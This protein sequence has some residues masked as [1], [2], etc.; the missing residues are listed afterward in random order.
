MPVREQHDRSFTMEL[1]YVGDSGYSCVFQKHGSRK[2]YITGT[3]NRNYRGSVRKGFA[4]RYVDGFTTF[5]N[6]EREVYRVEQ[7]R[8]VFIIRT[9]G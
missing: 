8:E 6:K 4:G 3:D 9:L 1:L 2:P 7:W 5:D